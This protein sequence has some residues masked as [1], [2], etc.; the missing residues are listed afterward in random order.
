MRNGNN[1]SI[2]KREGGKPSGY[3]G[4]DG[5]INIKMD[6]KVTG[7][8]LTQGFP[9]SRDTIVRVSCEHGDAS[10][11]S[12]TGGIFRKSQ[13]TIWLSKTTLVYGVHWGKHNTFKPYR[14]IEA[15]LQA[16]LM[17]ALN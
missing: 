7:C 11:G 13:G 4:V 10:S 14:K 6:L 12:I 5:R 17:S 2:G 8:E 16:F 9:V 15:K 3:L 1:V